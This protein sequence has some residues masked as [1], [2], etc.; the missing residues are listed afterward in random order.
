MDRL[1]FS[2]V[3][4]SMTR[5]AESAVGIFTPVANGAIINAYDHQGSRSFY[6]LAGYRFHAIRKAEDI[7]PDYGVETESLT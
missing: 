4:T 1:T 5:A 7:L 6:C 3:D 2:L